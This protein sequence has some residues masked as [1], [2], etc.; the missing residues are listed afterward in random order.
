MDDGIALLDLPALGRAIVVR[1]EARGWTTHRLSQRSGIGDPHIRDIER[2]K[3]G[4]GVQVLAKIAHALGTTPV[5][6]LRESGVAGGDSVSGDVVVLYE[7]LGQHERRT[8]L[9]IGRSLRELQAE[10][11]SMQGKPLPEDIAAF[12]ETD[13]IAEEERTDVSD[14]EGA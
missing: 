6:L 1:R 13:L 3:S 9:Q 14:F 7:E 12:S 11:E 8:W 5:E 4:M 10:Y 2:G